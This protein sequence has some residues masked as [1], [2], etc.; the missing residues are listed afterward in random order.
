MTEPKQTGSHNY[1]IDDLVRVMIRVAA[2]ERWYDQS[3]LGIPIWQ[4]PEDLM[5]LQSLVVDIRPKWI[6][7]TGTKFGGSAIF[8]ASL[9]QLLGHSEGGVLTVDIES[10]AEARETFSSHPLKSWVRKAIVDD[11]ASPE[12]VAAFRQQIEED[13]GTVM[14]FLDDN[15]NADHV[16]SEMEQYASLVT[17]NSY[18]VVADTV[19]A[20]LG[21][22]PVGKPNPKYPSV[23]DSNPRIAITEFMQRRDDFIRDD[24]FSGRGIGNFS[25]GFLKRVK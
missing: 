13:P 12:V 18:M 10:Q 20:D 11:A 6:I 5:R 24:R 16:L 25:D 22:T 15:H 7:E 14:V 2:N 1:I 17:V 3:W 21:G 9:L 23:T 19:F 8:F 4:L